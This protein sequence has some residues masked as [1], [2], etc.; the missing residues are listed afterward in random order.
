MRRRNF[1]NS[2]GLAAFS[3]S[4]LSTIS[5]DGK[6]Y[7][8]DNP[9]TTDILGP[10]YRPGSPMRSN[11][12]PPGAKGKI[13]NLTGVVRAEDGKKTIAGVRLEAWQC[14]EQMKYDNT[15][16][17]YLYRGTV[18]TDA[19]GKYSFRTIVPIPYKDGN[20]WRPAHIHLR[21]SS[22]H[23]QDLITQVYFTGDPYIAGDVASNTASSAS[24]ILDITSKSNGE[25]E[26]RFDITLGKTYQLDD[27]GFN[28]ICGLYQLKDG[29]VEFYRQDDLLFM[30]L[31]GQIMEG[32]Y[33]RGNNSFEGGQNFIRA[34]FDIQPSKEVSVKID[35]WDIPSQ[36]ALKQQLEGV[37]T[38]K[39]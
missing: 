37:K 16:D 32:M 27:A 34:R 1:L 17:E 33:Y 26:V 4:A 24:R 22:P 5:W 30:K 20:D 14:D 18:L 35:L 8:A 36:P 10:Y 38:L 6:S 3:V 15:S 39:Y 19:A 21:V 11:L 9:T 23:H 28:K 7:V 13:M 31:N 29:M 12:V 2:A 25:H